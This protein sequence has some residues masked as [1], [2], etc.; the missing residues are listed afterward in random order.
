[1]AFQSRHRWV[2]HKIS[3]TFE[4]PETTAEHFLSKHFDQLQKF[5]NPCPPRNKL[6]VYYQ[7]AEE[8]SESGDWV[9]VTDEPV[10][11][12]TYGDDV[13]LN[14]QACYFVRNIPDDKA[15]DTGVASDSSL[16]FGVLT[17]QPLRDLEAVV[18][19]VYLP[20]FEKKKDW[21]VAEK[22][23]EDDFQTK[24]SDFVG[25]IHDDIENLVGG[26]ELKKPDRKYEGMDVRN[27][28]TDADTVAHFEE[29]LETWCDEIETYLTESSTA[30]EVSADAG[31]MTELE[32]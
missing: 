30:D 6:F 8:K 18:R 23:V 15:I 32:W 22:S 7:P 9:Q 12:F 26:I 11:L 21:G 14:G 27:I 19:S 13:R 29:L 3:R 5:F 16:F 31:P 24:I 17:E 28:R 10:L 20:Y 25:T 2:L 4:I 1:M